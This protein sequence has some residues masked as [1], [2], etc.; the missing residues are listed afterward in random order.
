MNIL[1]LTLNT[2]DSIYE[3]TI[4]A[5]LLRE[6]LN[7]GHKV[8]TVSPIEERYNKRKAD[9]AAGANFNVN[10]ATKAAQEVPEG[11]FVF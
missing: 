9:K 4:Y 10:A 6:F 11:K 2:F 8:F 5:D 1:F 7:N 3:H